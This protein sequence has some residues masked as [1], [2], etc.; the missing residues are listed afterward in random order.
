MQWLYET[1]F[2]YRQWK[3][4]HAVE[5]VQEVP[6]QPISPS[7]GRLVRFEGEAGPEEA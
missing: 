5:K 1:R 7:K 3:V 6:H 4:C 2:D